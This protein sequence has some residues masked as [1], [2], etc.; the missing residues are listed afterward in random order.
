MPYISEPYRMKYD[1]IVDKIVEEL[2]LNGMGGHY[3]AGHLNYILSKIINDTLS[4]QGLNYKN[5]NSIVGALECSKMELYRRVALPYEDL[6]IQ[7][8][9]DVYKIDVREA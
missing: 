1:K 8:N 2:N 3:P 9:G 7:S 5:I 4:R 6:K